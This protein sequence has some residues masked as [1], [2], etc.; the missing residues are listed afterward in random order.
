[1]DQD[2]HFYGAFYAA[3]IGGQ[4]NREDATTIAKASNF[5]DFLS[6]E[7]YA[8][9]WRLVHDTVKPENGDFDVAAKVDYP[10][11]SFQGT[12]SAGLSGSKGLWAA[13]HFTPGNYD[14]PPGTPTSVE[15]H[16]ESVA[17]RL[18]GHTLRDVTPDSSL[19]IDAGVAK[20]LNRP[21]N[22]LSRTLIKDT[23]DCLQQPERLKAVLSMAAGGRE[24][25]AEYDNEDILKR[26][27]LLLLGAR[28]HVIADTWAHQDW[29]AVNNS[30]NTYWDIDGDLIHDQFYQNIKYRYADGDDWEK[31]HLSSTY[32]LT[33]ENFAAVPNA[34]TYLGHGWMG[35]FPDYSFIDYYYKPCWRP[36]EAAPIERNNR[37]EY[38]NAFLELCS[39]FARANNKTFQPRD[40][41][42]QLAAAQKAISGHCDLSNA[43]NCPRVFSSGLW[44]NEMEQLGIEKPLD[45]IDT[46]KEPDE[47]ATLNGLIHHDDLMGTRYGTYYIHLASDLYLFQIAVDYHFQFVKHWLTRNHIGAGLF[48]GN[49]SRAY[50][51]LPET[52]NEFFDA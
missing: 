8:G 32:Q 5:I 28:A 38:A 24:L 2:F 15:I 29:S 30:V 9:Y 50:G 33:N 18:P 14:D 46:K 36:K 37:T 20:L 7:A 13:F 6:N 16:G 10:R 34:T 26:F 25:L 35:H 49:W 19:G 4:Y 12:L 43:D 40:V 44:M 47:R 21:Q 3:K 51:P 11:Y 41:E 48:D 22:P 31:V 1:M 17:A 39:M 45:P 27:S 52:I 42:T 23:V